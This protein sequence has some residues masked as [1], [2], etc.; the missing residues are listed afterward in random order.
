[1]N[2]SMHQP[3]STAIE[4]EVIACSVDDAV[5]AYRGGASR[6]EVTIRLDQAGLTPPLD[7]VKEIVRSVPLPVRVM[8]RDR[9]DFSLG[10]DKELENLMR[11]AAGFATLNVGARAGGR[12]DGLVAGHIKEEHLDLGVLGKIVGTA[13]NLRVTVHHAIEATRDPF[14]TLRAL[15]KCPNVDK[16]LVSGGTGRIEERIARLVKLQEAFGFE[17][18]LI[19]GGNLTLEMLKPLRAATG[20]RIFHLGRAVRTPGESGGRVD[21]AKVRMAAELLDIM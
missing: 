20:I 1:M 8:L 11:K 5:E 15:R 9:P 2:A 12:V 10:G 3:E 13:P 21:R 19:A 4:L 17:R 16:A 6:L 18:S 14:Q 7:M